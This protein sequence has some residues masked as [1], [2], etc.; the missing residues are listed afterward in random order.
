MQTITLAAEHRTAVR[1]G[2]GPLRRSGYLPAVLYGID[3]TPQ[4]I[5]LNSREATKIINRIIGTALIDLTL[6][7]Q[8]HKTL[9]REVQ[10]NFVTDEILHVD[11]F[12]VAMDRVMRVYIPVR[13]VGA[14]PAVVTL[15]GVLVRG[16]PE[17]EIEC[18]PGDLIQE[19]NADLSAIKQINE[20]IHVSDL[21]V[22]P[23]IKILTHLDEQIA[24]VTYAAQEEV[25][26]EKP[27]VTGEVEV[28]EK[29]KKEEE[30]EEEK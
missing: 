21:R 8:S 28:V 1:K 11:F 2:L 6:D 18:L 9:L 19:V 17:I 27:E 7:G 26:A 22:P 10:R 20:S 13:L 14:S 30:G 5:Q 4:S 12:E 25:A 24:R 15:G 16:L 23:T 3:K 29:G